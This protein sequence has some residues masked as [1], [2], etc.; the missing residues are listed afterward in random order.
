MGYHHV[1][2]F[3]EEDGSLLA[4]GC[5]ST[6]EHSEASVP[7]QGV[8]LTKRLAFTLATLLTLGV[9][10]LVLSS[11]PTRVTPMPSKVSTAQGFTALASTCANYPRIE[12]DALISNH[13]SD[14]TK[15]ITF[16]GIYNNPDTHETDVEV[17]IRM[18]SDSYSSS[19]EAGN[20]V[21]NHFI[22]IWMD[23]N[24]ETTLKVQI[25]GKASGEPITVS[26]IS[27]TF[28]DIDSKPGFHEKCEEVDVAP[29][30]VGL[31]FDQVTVIKD[32]VDP[33]KLRFI[34]TEGQS[35]PNPDRPEDLTEDQG[36]RAAQATFIA[37]SE[38]D[39][40][41]STGSCDPRKFMMVAQPIV[42]CANFPAGMPK[43]TPIQPLQPLSTDIKYCLWCW[44]S[45]S[46]SWPPCSDEPAW[47][48]KECSASESSFFLYFF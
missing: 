14:P 7:R 45:G 23:A 46:L 16:H 3:S 20:K 44:I 39:I 17:E 41:L 12:V 48:A 6:E 43:P 25:V 27:W 32:E 37:Q 10:G 21:E 30:D 42:E 29:V 1:S 13:L 5:N 11:T 31:S 2:M 22:S 36:K 34:N 4:D 47:W 26:K 33:T 24:S 19:R 38:M 28:F 18:T 40:T 15:G 35:Y 8:W 9:A